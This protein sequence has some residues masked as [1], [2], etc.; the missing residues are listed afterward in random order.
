LR[1]RDDLLA[2][3]GA[4]IDLALAGIKEPLSPLPPR[5]DSSPPIAPVAGLTEVV[6]VAAIATA[7][8]EEPIGLDHATAETERILHR[9]LAHQE[10]WTLEGD[11]QN[12]VA[13]SSNP[14]SAT[15]TVSATATFRDGFADSKAEA[16][17]ALGW[18]IS[19][20]GWKMGLTGGAIYATSGF[21]AL[22]LLS[23]KVR[24]YL[25]SNAATRDWVVT[26]SRRELA[27]I[28]GELT[29]VL[30]RIAPEAQTV[31]VKKQ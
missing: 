7:E 20:N 29:L 14:G 23:S 2:K 1:Q 28:A 12:Y 19:G 8:A 9:V 17:Q 3:V 6:S 13:V 5:R 16:L 26:S 10:T 18:N 11:D 22:A 24:N 27:T 21:G 31:S 4:E 25:L 30:Q 15:T